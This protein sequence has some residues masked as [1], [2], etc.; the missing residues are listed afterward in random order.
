MIEKVCV[1]MR[2]EV[3]VWVGEMEAGFI[4][5]LGQLGAV[6]CVWGSVFIGEQQCESLK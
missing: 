1:C 3:M 2:M 6:V 5:V 4:C